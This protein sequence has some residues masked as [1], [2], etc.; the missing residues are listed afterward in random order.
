MREPGGTELGE[1]IRALLLE[2]ADMTAEAEMYLFMAA[3]SELLAEQIKPALK[4]GRTV[5]AD[6]YHDS[7]L[8]YQGWGRGVAT[9]WPHSF[10]VPDLTLL[11][12]LPP[13][14]AIERLRR[15]GKEL[16]R[17]DAEPVDFHRRVAAGYEMLAAQE[18]QRWL[19]VDASQPPEAVHSAIMLRVRELL[20]P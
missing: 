17:L 16:D 13:E 2:G 14:V 12:A 9:Q 7:T 6:R 11:L 10:P 20:K 4:V 15:S 1:R 5:I 8:A 18:P 19:R 3:R